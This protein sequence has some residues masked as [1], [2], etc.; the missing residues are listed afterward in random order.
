MDPALQP[1]S[2]NPSK[3]QIT[4][5]NTPEYRH[6]LAEISARACLSDAL[7]TLFQGE[8]IGSA[9]QVTVETLYI[10]TLI[11]IETKVAL[12]SL[13]VEADNFAAVV[14]WEPPGALRN[15]DVTELEEIAKARPIYVSF[16]RDIQVARI[17]CLGAEQKCWQFT[18]MARDPL[19]TSKGA[20]RAVMEPFLQ[21][22]KEERLPVWCVAGNERARNV[23]AYFGFRV[24]KVVYSGEEKVRTWCMVCNWPVE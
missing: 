13:I 17:E 9:S 5:S 16:L 15:H 24:V 14:C 18:L 7:N 4:S 21:R 20:V 2:E 23:Y 8:K 6:R 12:D 11:R 1:D 3:P 19:R 22:A 10:S